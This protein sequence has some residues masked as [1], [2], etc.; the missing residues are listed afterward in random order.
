MTRRLVVAAGVLG[1]VGGCDTVE[2]ARVHVVY[3]QIANFQSFVLSSDSTSSYGGDGVF[4]LYKVDS[5]SNEGMLAQEFV[6]DPDE[7]LTVTPDATVNEG[8]GY[9]SILLSDQDADGI[10]VPAGQT[11]AENDGLGC[12]VKLAKTND[13]EDLATP[14]RWSS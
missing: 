4:V 6:F 12:F 3:E 7:L 11:L 10:V 14:R 9:D 13:L 2:E 1:L 8:S 5:I